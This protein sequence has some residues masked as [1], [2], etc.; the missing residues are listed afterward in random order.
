MA[1][2]PDPSPRDQV[3][4]RV[5]LPVASDKPENAAHL[6][7]KADKGEGKEAS[8]DQEAKPPFVELSPKPSLPR[9][10]ADHPPDALNASKAPGVATDLTSLELDPRH[11]YASARGT[12]EVCLVVRGLV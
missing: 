5:L 12:V 3:L 8:R 11:G 10:S 6:Q 4:H 7:E 1:L 2:Q 9:F